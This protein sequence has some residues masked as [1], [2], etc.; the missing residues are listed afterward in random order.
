MVGV[1][2]VFVN[3]GMYNVFYIVIKVK[4]SDGIEI[5]LILKLK[6]VM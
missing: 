3:E 1:Y 2:S 4:F 6:C 5:D